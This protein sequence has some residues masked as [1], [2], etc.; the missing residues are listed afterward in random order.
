MN[1]NIFGQ[2]AANYQASS[3]EKNERVVQTVADALSLAGVQPTSE[4]GRVNMTHARALSRSK[5]FLQDIAI[6]TV[7]Q[8]KQ[9]IAAK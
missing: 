1:Q 6:A 7:E 3:D 8:A 4:D 5:S 9:A 2:V